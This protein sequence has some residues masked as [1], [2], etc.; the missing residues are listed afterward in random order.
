MAVSQS[1]LCDSDTLQTDM[2]RCMVFEVSC[3][4]HACMY[5][6][7]CT[8]ALRSMEDNETLEQWT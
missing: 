7:A 3:I 2:E 1:K 8:Y 6:C 4:I 5:V